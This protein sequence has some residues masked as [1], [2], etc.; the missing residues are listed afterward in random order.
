MDT[1]TLY[2][3]LAFVKGPGHCHTGLVNA[4]LQPKPNDWYIL[5]FRKP[6]EEEK[7]VL[8]SH[9]SNC[10]IIFR[11]PRCCLINSVNDQ[12]ELQFRICFLGP[13]CPRENK[14][15]ELVKVRSRALGIERHGFW[16]GRFTSFSFDE[17]TVSTCVFICTEKELTWCIAQRMSKADQQLKDSVFVQCLEIQPSLLS[18]ALHRASLWEGKCT[19]LC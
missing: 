7:T 8:L 17:E 3:P 6:Q 13:V 18:E 5:I 10:R 4:C 19:D 1:T 15:D 11:A 12:A 16:A 2:T 14:T 9:N